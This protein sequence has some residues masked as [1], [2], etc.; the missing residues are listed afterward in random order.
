M[1]GDHVSYE[2]DFNVRYKVPPVITNFCYRL[3]WLWFVLPT[4]F[5]MGY[6]GEMN[7]LF[8]PHTLYYSGR[9]S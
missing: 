8:T 2:E 1:A 5:I 4:I 9:P 6:L 7:K 3:A